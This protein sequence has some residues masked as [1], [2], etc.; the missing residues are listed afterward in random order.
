MRSYRV[1]IVDDEPHLTKILKHSFESVGYE[2]ATAADGISCLNSVSHFRPDL[3]IMDIMMP[4]VSGIEA[5]KMIRNNPDFSET[6]IVALSARIDEEATEGMRDA[7]ADLYLNKPF[8]VSKLLD[9]V[10][11]LLEEQLVKKQV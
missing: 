7:G 5:V 9:R 4:H 11:L 10:S 6:L 1:L 8:T 2:V 3:I